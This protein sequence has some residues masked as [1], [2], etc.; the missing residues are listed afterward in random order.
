MIM[1]DSRCKQLSQSSSWWRMLLT[2]G[3]RWL[4]LHAAQ[5][6]PPT[7]LYCCIAAHRAIAREL[8]LYV[9]CCCCR[10]RWIECPWNCLL[11]GGVLIIIHALFSDSFAGA[12]FVFCSPMMDGIEVELNCHSFGHWI[13][14]FWLEVWTL[15]KCFDAAAGDLAPSRVKMIAKFRMFEAVSRRNG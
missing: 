13:I 11:N 6:S 14:A 7:V 12:L 4:S 15:G 3:G 2:V 8:W 9:S 5:A 1:A 10:C